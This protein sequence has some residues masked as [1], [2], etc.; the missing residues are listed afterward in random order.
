MKKNNKATDSKLVPSA[1]D[2]QKEIDILKSRIADKENEA[3]EL[4]VQV[5]DINIALNVF[6]GE[7]DSKVGLLYVKL[8]R[9]KL[10][11]KEYRLRIDNFNKGPGTSQHDLD[12][13]EDEVKQTFTDE[14]QSINDLEDEATEAA[15]EYREY[16]EQEESDSNL[17]TKDK[18]GLKKMFRKLA[19]K[20]HPDKAKDDKRRKEYHGIMSVINE[21]YR[22]KDLSTLKK[23]MSRAEREEKIAKE[24][25]EET[26]ARLKADYDT[27]LGIIAKRNS[28]LEELEK[29]ETYK[30]KEKVEEA[31]KEDRDL[32]QELAGNIKE[33]ITENQAL[34]DGFVEKYKEIIQG[35]GF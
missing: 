19:L 34:L 15:D 6:L 23:Y 25:P 27:I 9:I 33:E 17:N 1:S 4:L 30:L 7:Y 28:E 13:I 18:E 29:D 16:L 10:K 12:K 35:M 5:Q 24:T 26:L 22:N 2:V 11:V 8:D 14:R 32:L 31:K 21:A 3:S 20:F